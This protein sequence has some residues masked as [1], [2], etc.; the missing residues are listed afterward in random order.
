MR[1]RG[2][3]AAAGLS[4]WSVQHPG[5]HGMT[6]DFAFL[7]ERVAIFVDGC[8]WHACARCKKAVRIVDEYWASKLRNNRLRDARQIRLLKRMGWKT[9]RLWEHEV[10][11]SPATCIAKIRGKLNP[12]GAAR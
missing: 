8:F 12:S 4:G 10:R 11:R 9:L 1:L 5:I 7:S 6:P 2:A 3:L